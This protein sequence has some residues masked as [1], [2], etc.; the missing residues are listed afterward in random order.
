MKAA[1]HNAM[2]E[3]GTRKS[4]LARK[5]GQKPTQ[6]DRLLDVEHSSKVETVELALHQLNRNVGVSVVVTAPF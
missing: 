4:E 2:I 6:I 1:L 3:T 5:M